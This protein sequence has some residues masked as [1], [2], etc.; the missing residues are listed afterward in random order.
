MSKF[1]IIALN[2]PAKPRFEQFIKEKFEHWMH[3][4]RCH[5]VVV[6]DK[7][8]KE[9]TDLLL[10]W[11]VEQDEDTMGDQYL[12]VT[13]FDPSAVNGWLPSGAWQWMCNNRKKLEYQELESPSILDMYHCGVFD[14]EFE[15]VRSVADIDKMLSVYVANSSTFA[16]DAVRS[17]MIERLMKK[18]QTVN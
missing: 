17:R 7:S 5:W 13:E 10:P 14:S 16:I 6:S 3:Y 12:F 11:V 15:R 4:M 2:R 9:I 18:L 1:Y 8:T